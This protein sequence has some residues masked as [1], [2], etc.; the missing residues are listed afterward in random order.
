MATQAKSWAIGTSVRSDVHK[1]TTWSIVL[2]VSMIL[3]GI[4]ALF[5][6]ATTGLAVTLVI[7]WLLIISGILHLGF[8]WRANGAGA[9]VGEILLGVLYGAIGVYLLAKPTLGLEAITFVLATYLVFEGVLELVIAIFLRP[10]PG[11]GWL[12]FDAIV[13]VLLAVLIWT[14]WPAS[15]T[16]VVGTL[17]AFSMFSSGVTRLIVS[18]AVRRVTA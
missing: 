7:G 10:L 5:V 2:S 4:L 6:P 1:A 3:T 15:S 16:W 17:V 11:S 14:G 13:T 9:V 18:M 12:L 8:A